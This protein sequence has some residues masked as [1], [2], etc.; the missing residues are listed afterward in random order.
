MVSAATI[1]L[2]YHIM[3]TVIDNIYFKYVYIIYFWL[4]FFL[5][6]THQLF[7]VLVSGGYSLV[8]MHRLLLAVDALVAEH[9]F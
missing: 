6:A 8:D 9:R 3:K 2:C 7:L 1:Q 4:C 5:I